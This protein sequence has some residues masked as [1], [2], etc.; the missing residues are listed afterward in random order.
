MKSEVL[1]ELHPASLV[2]RER[3]GHGCQPEQEPRRGPPI[4]ITGSETFFWARMNPERG[5][6]EPV[7]DP[8]EATLGFRM[9]NRRISMDLVMVTSED[10]VLVNGVPSLKLVVL[11]PKD[12][13]MLGQNRLFY[14][15]QRV[16]P[17]VGAPTEA[18]INEKCPFCRIPIRAES[19]VVSC[20]C[21]AVYHN[22]PPSGEQPLECF[23]KMNNCLQCGKE[24]ST[25]EYLVWDPEEL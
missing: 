9:V 8:D 7:E 1:Y 10:H 2:S 4:R 17:H 12:S 21:G 24:M 16:K 25:R 14:V 5:T 23:R 19:S 11:G 15:T 13:V 3:S 22:E 20:S 6:L 18:M